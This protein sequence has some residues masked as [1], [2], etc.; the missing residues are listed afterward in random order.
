MKLRRQFL[1]NAP[2]GLLAFATSS[3]AALA[4]QNPPTPGA[5]PTFGATPAVGPEV[6]AT[7][8]AEAEKLMQVSMTPAEREMAANGWIRGGIP[9]RQYVRDVNC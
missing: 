2:L 5:P 1:M 6:T 9:S 7:T 4:E 3:R 8:F